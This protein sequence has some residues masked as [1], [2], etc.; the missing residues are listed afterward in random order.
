[1]LKST[2]TNTRAIEA[3]LLLVVA[4]IEELSNYSLM[5]VS[6]ERQCDVSG[7]LF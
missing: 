2:C 7:T 5:G 6:I 3:L 1:M 4:K